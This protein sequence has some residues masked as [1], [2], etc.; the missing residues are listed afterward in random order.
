M[1]KY[2]E[3]ILKAVNG[4]FGKMFSSAAAVIVE[5]AV[6]IMDVYLAIFVLDPADDRRLFIANVLMALAVLSSLPESIIKLR[7]AVRDFKEQ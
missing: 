7:G 2:S 6:I 3:M 5:A 1:V 4:M